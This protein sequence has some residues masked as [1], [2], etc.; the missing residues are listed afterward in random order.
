V[1]V[2]SLRSATHPPAFVWRRGREVV[3][4]QF[5]ELHQRVHERRVHGPNR[6]QDPRKPSVHLHRWVWRGICLDRP[7]TAAKCSV[8]P[9]YTSPALCKR[10]SMTK[11]I[12]AVA[13]CIEVVGRWGGTVRWRRYGKNP[14]NSRTVPGYLRLNDVCVHIDVRTLTHRCTHV[15]D[16]LQ[17][18]VRIYS[19]TRRERASNTGVA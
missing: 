14:S 5:L 3:A 16:V 13:V 8:S 12:G 18:C 10:N 7:K 17:V 2:R 19:S 6:G 11:S 15:N 9:M 1:P 4:D